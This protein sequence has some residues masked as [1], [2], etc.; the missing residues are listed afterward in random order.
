MF[1]KLY[2]LYIYVST[3][4]YNKSGHWNIRECLDFRDSNNCPAGQNSG[5]SSENCGYVRNGL[6]LDNAST[7]KC[8]ETALKG[9]SFPANNTSH[10]VKEKLRS[11]VS[12][13]KSSDCKQRI[14]HTNSTEV[15]SHKHPT[16]QS[17]LKHPTSQSSLK[18][19]A[20]Q[21]SLK[22]P[23]SQ[24][25]LKHPASQSSLKHPASQSS[26]K[27][28]NSNSSNKHTTSQISIK[29]TNSYLKNTSK[30]S[31]KPSKSHSSLTASKISRKQS[32][33]HCR[34]DSRYPLE[35]SSTNP[36]T[37]LPKRDN[38][39]LRAANASSSSDCRCE[40]SATSAGRGNKGHRGS[41]RNC[42]SRTSCLSERPPFVANV[43]TSKTHN[44]I[45]DHKQVGV[46][47]TCMEGGRRINLS[48]L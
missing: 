40:H 18:H 4:R 31:L 21:S 20:S 38:S 3:L 33:H 6:G 10:V 32:S 2:L 12:K 23:N 45:M 19:P 36:S 48:S 22:H 43:K 46:P 35:Q 13:S 39:R 27:H 1:V 25:S 16:S 14:S 29:P 9:L 5:T 11:N 30:S 37:P 42:D 17:S 41:V 44:V 34:N 47:T 7:P 15:S 24:S 8:L 26:L 28:P